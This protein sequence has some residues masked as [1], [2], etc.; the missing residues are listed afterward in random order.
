MVPAMSRLLR[1]CRAS[2][3]AL[4]AAALVIGVNGFEGA[5]HSVHHLP[6][7]V[8]AHAHDVMSDGHDEQ[9]GSPVSGTPASGKE[10]PCSVAEAASQA[11]ATSVEPPATPAP[12]AT[13]LGLVALGAPD[14][15]RTAWREPGSERAP[16]STRSAS[17]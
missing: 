16:P 1:A 7:A 3:A 11:S 4:L 5:I 14:P 2:A 13:L 15:V 17:S 8:D 9:Q 12:V 10:A 6:A